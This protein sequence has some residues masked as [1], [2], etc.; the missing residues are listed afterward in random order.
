MQCSICGQ[1]AE[2]V[3]AYEVHR[4]L[5]HEPWYVQVGAIA[6]GTLLF[7]ALLTAVVQASPKVV[8]K[9]Y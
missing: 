9:L 5:G 6:L 2:S 7:T 8:R 1:V 3:V 4:H